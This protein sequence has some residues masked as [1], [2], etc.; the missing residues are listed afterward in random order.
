MEYPLKLCLSRS[1]QKVIFCLE[2]KISSQKQ[3]PI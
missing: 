3:N 1:W 2:P